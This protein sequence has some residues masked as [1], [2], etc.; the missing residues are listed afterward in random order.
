MSREISAP[1]EIAIT[2]RIVEI[3]GDELLY[4]GNFNVR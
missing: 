3:I 4:I 2:S 1:A